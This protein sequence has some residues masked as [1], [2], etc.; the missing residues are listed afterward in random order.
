MEEVLRFKRV[1]QL[2]QNIV[3][4]DT[5][6]KRNE[7]NKDKKM[8]KEGYTNRGKNSKEKEG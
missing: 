4:E 1:F 6:P 5:N 3:K 2:H 8:R 7:E